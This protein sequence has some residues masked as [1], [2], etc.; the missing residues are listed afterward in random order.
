MGGVRST[1]V[2]VIAHDI[3]THNTKTNPSYIRNDDVIIRAVEDGAQIVHSNDCVTQFS[4][5]SFTCL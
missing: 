4:G 3:Q 1:A 5:S 2:S